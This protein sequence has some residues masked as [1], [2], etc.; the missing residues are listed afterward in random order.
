M[1]NE[2]SL[3]GGEPVTRERVLLLR[4]PL[5]DFP[6][7]R[8]MLGGVWRWRK[9]EMEAEGSCRGNGRREVLRGSL[10]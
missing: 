2:S 4:A 1:S 3:G 7:S 10:R 8:G 6:L 9:E 5:L